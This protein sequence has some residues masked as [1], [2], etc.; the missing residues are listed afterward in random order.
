MK[1]KEFIFKME[2][3]E[4]EWKK[5]LTPEQYYVLREA[6][7]ERPFTGKYNMHFEEGVY[8]CAACGEKLFSSSS[9]FDS[10][11][12]WPSFDEEIE[13]GK[14]VE[15]LDRSHGMT[16]MEIL[17]GNCGSHLGHVF[18]DGPTNTGLRYCVNSLSL[19]FEKEKKKE[20]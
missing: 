6:G 3:P 9:K 16:R 1:K 5:E 19:D 10:H 18:N 13:K 4:S 20:E 7:T 11:C 15:R 2:K 8:K 14:I 12:G 17:C